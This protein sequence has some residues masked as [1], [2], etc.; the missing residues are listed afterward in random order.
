MGTPTLVHASAVIL[1]E[2]S[3][4]IR[5]DSGVGKSS[6][7]LALIDAWSLRGEFAILVSDDRVAC[8]TLNGRVLLSPHDIVAGLVEWRGLGLLPRPYELKAL[9]TLIVD[10]G[11]CQMNDERSRLPE[12]R[13][14]CCDFNGLR[15]L[16]R[17]RL[18]AR[19]TCQ[20]VATIM[21]F[22]HRLP[23]K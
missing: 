12:G 6:L 15:N 7:A 1:G 22:L 13:D 14:L 3:V 23:T 19:Q 4:L 20:S 8:R 2:S 16:V 11:A 5:G 9:L 21:A 18:P 10:L 17:L